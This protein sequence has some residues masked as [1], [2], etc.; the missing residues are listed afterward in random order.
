MI[1]LASPTNGT[2]STTGSFESFRTTRLL[3]H[4]AISAYGTYPPLPPAPTMGPG[5]SQTHLRNI[6]EGALGVGQQGTRPP[7]S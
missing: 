1:P 6:S 2:G 5:M 7:L 3:L 4:D